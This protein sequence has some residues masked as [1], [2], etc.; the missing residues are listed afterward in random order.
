METPSLEL[1]PTAMP[2]GAQVGAWRVHGIRGRGTYGTVYSAV[3][4]GHPGD[5]HVPAVHQ[6]L[7]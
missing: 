4:H 5:R 2:L 3:K 1:D 7:L 6:S